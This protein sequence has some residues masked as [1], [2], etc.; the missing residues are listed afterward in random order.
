VSELSGVPALTLLNPWGHLIAHGGKNI[1]NRTWSPP[2]S[3]KR[4]LIHAGKG[5]DAEA[6]PRAHTI[7]QSSVATSAIVAVVEVVRVCDLSRWTTDLRCACNEWAAAGQNHWWLGS[8]RALPVPV[9]CSGRQRLWAPPLSVV[10]AV[11]DQL[12]QAVS[13]V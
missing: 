4:L 3:V 13:G 12:E 10:A 7:P 8:V 2:R 5:W 6:I 11:D 1:E 9:P